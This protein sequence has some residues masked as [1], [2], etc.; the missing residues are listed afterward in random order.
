MKSPRG[1]IKLLKYANNVA[2]RTHRAKPQAFN[3]DVA[4]SSI[5]GM[6]ISYMTP[7]VHVAHS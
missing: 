4:K 1:I 3:V 6:S 2:L 7:P 5:I